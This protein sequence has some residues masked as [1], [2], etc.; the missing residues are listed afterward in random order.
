MRR[1]C[2]GGGRGEAEE[3]VAPHPPED[4][5]AAA[6]GV[7]GISGGVFLLSALLNKPPP[8]PNRTSDSESASLSS[9]ARD[10]FNRRAREMDAAAALGT[11][12]DSWA[13]DS[14]RQG[15]ETA[16]AASAQRVNKE[17]EEEVLC[18]RKEISVCVSY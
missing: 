8:F 17:K 3:D 13:L 7:T 4:L 9:F 1:D 6:R 12:P 5:P 10:L 2:G 14:V 15:L 11:M 16:V 18:W